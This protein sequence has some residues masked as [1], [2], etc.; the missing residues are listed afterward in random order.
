MKECVVEVI[1]VDRARTRL[2]TIS[3]HRITRAGPSPELTARAAEGGARLI[4]VKPYRARHRA[5]EHDTLAELSMT[6]HDES[7]LNRPRSAASAASSEVASAAALATP[8]P[9][10]SPVRRTALEL[11][12]GLV[13]GVVGASVFGP[14]MISFWYEPPSKDAFSCASSV[15]QALKDFL[16][17]QLGLALVGAL[18]L[19]LASFLVRRFFRQRRERRSSN[20]G[21]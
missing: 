15:E 6:P 14:S 11:A 19:V 12:I 2:G 4:L 18:V 10:S 17:L 3:G 5:L 9:R 20:T 7:N 8:A 16:K 13:A 21:A 1:R